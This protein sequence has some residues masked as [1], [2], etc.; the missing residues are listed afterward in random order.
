MNQY[1]NVELAD[2]HFIYSLA[3]RNRH[4]VVRLH[5]EVYSTGCNRIIKC[6]SEFIKIKWDM[7]PSGL[8]LKLQGGFEQHEHQYSKRV[9]RML[10]TDMQILV[11]GHLPL[12][13]EDL[14]QLSFVYCRDKLTSFSCKERALI[15]TK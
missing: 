14:E 2:I 11:C 13:L 1:A 3:N 8:R 7:D 5:G 9:C 6:L 15:I 4:A 10:I 12:Q